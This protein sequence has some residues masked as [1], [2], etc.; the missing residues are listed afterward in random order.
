MVRALYAP[1][2]HYGAMSRRGR[3]LMLESD[4][5][6]R[7]IAAYSLKLL[8]LSDRFLAGERTALGAE[9]RSCADALTCLLEESPLAHRATID[10]MLDRYEALRAACDS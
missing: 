2:A 1:G 8:A 9:A 4:Q 10:Y 3:L 5:V 7:E 6:V